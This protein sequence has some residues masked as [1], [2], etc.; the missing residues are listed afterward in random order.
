MKNAVFL[1]R[2]G[3]ITEDPPHYAHRIDQVHIIPGSGEAIRLLN[4]NG[5]LVIVVSNQAGVARGYYKE[6]D[7]GIFNEE[8]KRQLFLEKARIDAIYYCPH[9]PD[10]V[11]ADYRKVCSCRKP[12][13]GMLIQAAEQY[14]VTLENSF[15]VGDKYS[16][17][18]AGTT[19]KCK[20]VMVLTG[21]GRDE[22]H[23]VV[24]S[25]TP[26]AENLLEAVKKYII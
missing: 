11:I 7:V 19:V 4:E 8:M 20:A 9:H 23:H 5:F 18:V 14:R 1:D 3:V 6:R 10:G 21:H 25:E 16:D 22:V 17:I 2:D 12:E 13:P 26:V 15:L 24:G